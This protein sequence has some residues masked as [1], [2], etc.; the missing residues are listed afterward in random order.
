MEVRLDGYVFAGLHSI[1]MVWSFGVAFFSSL[2]SPVEIPEHKAEKAFESMKRVCWFSE[3]SVLNACKASFKALK[4]RICNTENITQN[5]RHSNF[6]FKC[7]NP[8]FSVLKTTVYT[9]KTYFQ[10]LKYFNILIC[11]MNNLVIE[12]SVQKRCFFICCLPRRYVEHL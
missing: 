8:I 5:F 6:I 1:G 12:A 3:R 2:V 4:T 10:P 7:F 11:D 9:F